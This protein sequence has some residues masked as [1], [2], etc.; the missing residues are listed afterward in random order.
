MPE[1]VKDV[2]QAIVELAD[3]GRDFAVAVVLNS[4]GSTPCKAGAKAVIDRHGVIFGTIG[5]GL[6]EAE[7]Q[8]LARQAIGHGC[9]IV[10]DFPFDGAAACDLT[11]ICGG[12][13]RIL[14][15][16]TAAGHR[17]AYAA[18][19]EACRRRQRG[20]LLT[21]IQIDNRVRVEVRFLAEEVLSDHQE[22]PGTEAI[23]A[24][25][26]GEQAALF[27]SETNAKTETLEILV[28]PLIPKPVLLIVGGGHVGQA[29]ARQADLVG[30]EISVIDDRPEFT[31]PQLFPE[32]AATHCGG[33]EE[34]LS[35]FP[36]SKD[37][38]VVIVTRGHRQDADALAACLSRPVAYIGMIGSRRKVALVREAF[39]GSGRFSAAEFDRVY[40]PIGLDI[41]A[42]TVP[43]IAASIVAQ[44][45]G[46]RRGGR[47]P[48]ICPR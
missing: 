3:A 45:V 32:G 30:F 18:A 14:V 17:R 48:R 40:A 31:A 19:A 43:E 36:L 22:F 10:S 15:D 42:V 12:A 35:R 8:R 2:H 39:V 46:V 5:G 47:A 44:L 29:V 27:V 37:T 1:P 11:P 24:A 7:A 26:R 9:P 16:P 23:R 4:E 21:R 6:V 34:Q 33:I 38:Y 41:G 28:E 25:F 20:V 13:M